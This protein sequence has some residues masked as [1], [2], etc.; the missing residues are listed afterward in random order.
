MTTRLPP[1][2]CFL[3]LLFP[4]LLPACVT[5]GAMPPSSPVLEVEK[6]EIE[7]YNALV[8]EQEKLYSNC[9]KQ[10]ACARLKYT[11]ALVAL[12]EDREVATERFEEVVELGQDTQL[13][14]SSKLWI[15]FIQGQRSDSPW[16]SL[17]GGAGR[18]GNT[19][20]MLAWSTEQLVRDLLEREITIHELRK[21]R[22]RDIKV[23]KALKRRLSKRG[24]QLKRVTAE[25]DALKGQNP[26]SQTG[27]VAK[28]RRKLAA[29][30]KK[31][32]EL[33]NQL[34]ALKRIDQ[35]MRLRGVQ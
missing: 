5:G 21:K 29:R 11:S 20:E 35:E 12:F 17:I 19:S 18:S 27:S 31:I 4:L 25:R 26:K 15:K 1:V 28:L 7:R 32:E 14:A 10:D 2:G 22:I 34:E 3:L 9:G 16:S 8:E 6:G 33:T 24:K 30:G 13:A 23:V